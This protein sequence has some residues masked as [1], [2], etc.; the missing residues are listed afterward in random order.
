MIFTAH[1]FGWK[2]TDLNK[3]MHSL[4]AEQAFPFLLP[5]ACLS[6]QEPILHLGQTFPSKSFLSV[7]APMMVSDWWSK[8]LLNF[9]TYIDSPSQ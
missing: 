7:V 1:T 4:F 5:L 6:I 8:T 3:H 2:W 9:L